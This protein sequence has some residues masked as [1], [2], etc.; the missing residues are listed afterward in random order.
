MKIRVGEHEAYCFTAGRALDEGKRS[1][2][3]LHGAGLDHT[4]W[5]LAARHFAR[6]GRNVIVPD[7]PGHGRSSGPGRESV[8]AMADWVVELLD[9]LGLEKIALAGHSMGSLVALDCAARYP[10]RITALAMVGTTVP[11]PVSEALL[12]DSRA[13]RHAAFDMLTQWGY[14]K[15][16]Q[17]GGNSNPG[18]WMIGATLRLFERSRPGVLHADMNACNAFVGGL[19]RGAAGRCPALLV[20]GNDDRL[21]P[22]RST[23]ALQQALAGADV[24]VLAD[25]GHTLMVEAPNALLDALRSIL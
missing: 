15:R 23:R 20:L 10:G 12:E 6:H 4:V 25:S 17:Y 19:G 16:H 14:S 13:D 24:R 11:M 22:P 5:T 18:I 8:A 3:L 9:A 21:T 1:V 7:L 2:L